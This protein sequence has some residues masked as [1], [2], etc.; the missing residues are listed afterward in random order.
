MRLHRPNF[1]R[2]LIIFGC[3]ALHATQHFHLPLFRRTRARDAPNRVQPLS[4]VLVFG[5]TWTL[6]KSKAARLFKAWQQW[7]RL[8]VGPSTISARC[9]VYTMI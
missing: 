9:P 3:T 5:V 7:I 8:K 6:A 2:T 1:G 4:Q